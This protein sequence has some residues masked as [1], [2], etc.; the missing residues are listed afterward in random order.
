[1]AGLWFVGQSQPIIVIEKVCPVCQGKSASNCSKCGGTGSVET[2][3]TCPKCNGSGKGEWNFKSQAAK[4][5]ISQSKPICTNCSGTG[6]KSPRRQCAQCQGKGK[7]PCPKC[8]ETGQLPKIITVRADFSRWEKILANL[9]I[10]PAANCRPQRKLDGSYPIIV[11]YIETFSTSAH[12]PR[13][14]KW[15][16]ARLVGSEWIIKT[17][18]ESKD[19]RGQLI[20]QGREFIIENREIKGSRKIE[21]NG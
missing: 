14:V 1:M 21:W 9:R 18:V 19:P 7:I 17:V 6:K 3:A 20:R 15:D 12:D 11:K 10:K 5:S 16:T 13:V 4:K 2:S 8:H